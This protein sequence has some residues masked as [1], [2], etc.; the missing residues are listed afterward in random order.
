MGRQ[1]RGQRRINQI[2]DSDRRGSLRHVYHQGLR[3]GHQARGNPVILGEEHVS[4]SRPPI[5]TGG[6]QPVKSEK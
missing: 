5:E 1:F 4:R 2:P 6:W 3:K